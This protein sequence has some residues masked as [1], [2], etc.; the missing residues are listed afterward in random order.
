MNKTVGLRFHGRDLRFQLSHGLFSSYD[1]DA[2]S[3]LLLKSLAARVD[4]ASLRSALDIGCGVGVIGACICSRAPEA[5]IVMQDRDALAAAFAEDNCRINGMAKVSVGCSLA[6]RGL[7]SGMFDLVTSNLPAKAG[8]PVLGSLL[9]HAAASLAPGGVAAVVII[10]PLAAF[11]RQSLSEMGCEIDHVE[12]TTAYAVIH[13]RT[14]SAGAETAAELEDL[15]PYIR[16]L[17]RFS[18][19][20]FDYSLRTA[21]SLPDFDTVGYA[22]GL[23]F[24]VAREAAIAGRL[25]AWNPGQGHLPVG[26]A[27]RPAPKITSVAIASRDALQC[28]IAALNLSSIGMVPEAVRTVCSE[29]DLGRAFPAGTYDAVIASP[30]PIP[31]VPWQAE[32]ADVSAGL[33]KPGGALLVVATSTEVHRFLDQRHGL[34]LQL[35]RKHAGC[36]A[37]LLRKPSAIPPSPV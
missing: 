16:S 33:L 21:H 37:V 11:A 5:N 3:R 17:S 15:Q 6:F 7:N 24:G 28:E 27:S 31:R 20:G 35:S 19:P 8:L 4:F 26:L 25:L 23:A 22:A 34:R 10:A 2:G 30:Q 9:R 36:R 32:L 29:G 1:I 13:Y 14:G 18:P 12:E